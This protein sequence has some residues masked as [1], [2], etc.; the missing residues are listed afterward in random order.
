MPYEECAVPGRLAPPGGEAVQQR[1]EEVHPDPG[2]RHRPGDFGGGAEDF[3]R[4]ECPHRV[5]VGGCDPS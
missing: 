1:G 2:R 4:R 3:R 5:G